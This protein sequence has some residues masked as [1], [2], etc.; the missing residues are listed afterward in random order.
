M[1]SAIR[2]LLVLKVIITRAMSGSDY[3]PL[4]VLIMHSQV[5]K[6]NITSSQPAERPIIEKISKRKTKRQDPDSD[7]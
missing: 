3:S 5:K 7:S 6:I 1:D 4:T 2:M